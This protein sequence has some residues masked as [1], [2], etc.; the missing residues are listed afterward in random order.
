MKPTTSFM[1]FYMEQ[2]DAVLEKQ[3]DLGMVL[4]GRQSSIYLNWPFLYQHIPQSELRK[5][6]SKMYYELSED[7]KRKYLEIAEKLQKAYKEEMK[8][9]QY[10]SRILKT[11]SL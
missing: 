3:P 7:K 8:K 1:L 2:K 4:E 9:F 11:E 6:I 5:I 10:V